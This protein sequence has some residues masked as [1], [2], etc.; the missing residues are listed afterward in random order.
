[1]SDPRNLAALVDELLTVQEQMEPLKAREADLKARIRDAAE[2]GE[3]AAGT[4]TI[5]LAPSRRLDLTAIAK[6]YPA[7]TYPQLY[8]STP[9]TKKVRAAFAP[10]VLDGFMKESG[11]PRVTIK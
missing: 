9:D 8:T 6:A 2:P 3:N 1:M 7:E 4:H 11:E 10:A 5:T